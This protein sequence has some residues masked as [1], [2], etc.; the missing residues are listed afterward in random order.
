MKSLFYIHDALC[1]E[2]LGVMLD[3]AREAIDRGEEVLWVYCDSSLQLCSMNSKGS[4]AKCKRCLM[5]EKAGRTQVIPEIKSKPLGVY[6]SKEIMT[7]VEQAEFIYNSFD[8]IKQL[9]YKDINIGYGVLSTYISLTR[10]NNPLIDLK[11]RNYC[12][13]LLRTSVKVLLLFSTLLDDYQ[14][15]RVYIFN[16][17][18]VQSRPALEVA[19]QRGI[20]L[21][22]MEAY[23]PEKLG[24][25]R[26]IIFINAMPHSISR[27]QEM[28]KK[29]WRQALISEKDRE[30]IARSF[31]EKRRNGKTAGDRVYTNHQV[32]GAL[33]EDWNETKENIVIFNSSEDEFVAIG[34]EWDE[35][36]F[37]TQLDGVMQIVEHYQQDKQK[38]FYLK[39][40][41]N[42]IPVK[43]RY[44]LDLYTLK[45]ANL[46][47]IPA[48]S[49]ISTYAMMDAASKVLVFGS[50]TGIEAAYWKKA[51]ILL[52]PAIYQNLG[53]CYKPK[54]VEQLW[55]LLDQPE[56]LPLNNE[57]VLKYGYFYLNTDQP[58]CKVNPDW[59][60][61]NLGYRKLR[62]SK[63]MTCCKS[64]YLFIL[65]TFL[66]V[67]LTACF[68]RERLFSE[69]PLDEA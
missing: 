50:T 56:L 35:T 33:P 55:E 44:H 3:E 65:Y 19:L 20:E 51:V 66:F 29:V 30:R 40:H 39:I 38:H 2:H 10:C 46:T 34:K 53:C 47:I 1:T 48:D 18:L 16:G 13:S 31:F 17:R 11:F 12:D 45:Y 37:P 59:I 42:L 21:Y 22:C 23:M 49:P 41:P 26:K 43:Y 69:L 62:F 24:F 54:N 67:V 27:N 4:K 7:E 32:Q 14:P 25:F 5:Y 57:N 52:G 8:D 58:V 36:L 9:H 15:D 6:I 61:I 68:C 64:S 63:F 28:M 60:T